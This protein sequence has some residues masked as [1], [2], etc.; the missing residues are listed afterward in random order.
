NEQTYSEESKARYRAERLERE[1]SAKQKQAQS[2]SITER[3]RLY[4]ELLSQLS[5]NDRA[6][7]DLLRRGLTPEKIEKLL[8]RSVGQWHP[9]HHAMTTE[10]P[11]VIGNGHKL[12][13]M[14][15]GYLVP[16]PNIDGLIV[17]AQYRVFEPVNGNKYPWLTSRTKNN[18]GGAKPNLPNG[19]LPIGVYR[20]KNLTR[21]EVVGIAEGYLKPSIA[22]DKVGH[23]CL[24]VAGG[25]YA[26]SPEQFTEALR[27]I[28][29]EQGIKPYLLL[30]PDAG[31]VQNDHVMQTYHR[32]YK[33]ATKLGYE[34]KVA[35]YGQFS[36]NKHQDIDELETVDQITEISWYQFLGLQHKA[37]AD[38]SLS[39]C[40]RYLPDLD[41]PEDAKLIGLKSPKGT[42]KTEY[43][44]RYVDAHRGAKRFLVICHRSQLTEQLGHRLGL[45]T[46]YELENAKG[47][48][49]Y[50]IITEI[51]LFG[52]VITWDSLHKINP[53]DWKGCEIIID[54]AE[55]S[56]WHLLN[57]S[58]EIESRRIDTLTMFSQLLE[59][60]DRTWL[61]DADLTNTAIEFT[62][63]LCNRKDFNPYIINN[64][65][66]FKKPWQITMYRD[67][68]A[69]HLVQVLLDQLGTGKRVICHLD[70]QKTKGKYSGKN[71]ERLVKNQYPHLR[72]LLIDSFTIQDP[73]HPTYRILTDE[74]ICQRLSGYD[75]VICTPTIET[76]VDIKTHG[77]FDAVFGI[78]HGVVSADSARQAL[79]RYREPV[80]RHVWAAAS[81]RM[82]GSADWKENLRM[83]DRAT[84]A[85]IRN[86]QD[87]D[88][89]VD[90]ETHSTCLDTWAKMM[91]RVKS[92]AISFRSSIEI[93]LR[94]EGHNIAIP[95]E[96]NEAAAKNLEALREI[97]NENRDESYLSERVAISNAPTV[98]DEQ[99]Q[100]IEELRSRTQSEA[101]QLRKH[102]LSK[103]YG[104]D[105]TP[106]L[107]EADDDGLRRKL[108]L[109]YYLTDGRKYLKS[110]DKE[111]L[112]KV[113]NSKG[114][115]WQPTANKTLLQ[116]KIALL[117]KLGI[118]QLLVEPDREY[119]GS[120]G[121]LIKFAK[122]CIKHRYELKTSFGM[123]IS[124]VASPITI[125]KQV[126]RL[127][128][129][130]PKQISRDK[131]ANGKAGH[132]VYKLMSII[133]HDLRHEVI[134]N[135]LKNDAQKMAKKT[136]ETVTVSNLELDPPKV[137]I[138]LVT[139]GGSNCSE[140]GGYNP[141]T[142][143]ILDQSA[144]PAPPPPQAPIQWHAGMRAMCDGF[145]YVIKQLGTLIVFLQREGSPHPIQRDISELTPIPS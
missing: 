69:N 37:L 60:C 36:K 16:I 81:A 33:L 76:G 48:Y 109:S 56:I 87:A 92:D 9:L 119:R 54:E 30:Y 59:N 124:P 47:Q 138:D 133:D 121:D 74:N 80:E 1:A 88:R 75:L 55:Q 5:L 106:E 110:R 23:I 28:T 7:N 39:I 13:V 79:S 77:L 52:M 35:W 21:K 135:W 46:H 41:I 99:A 57:A 97:I 142:G 31:A 25:N 128:G 130:S 117:D 67:N 125:L 93:G 50:G 65:Y 72:V 145:E 118:N 95:E 29:L 126:L 120:D 61:L 40:E 26:G 3:D 143:F 64:T 73:D 104:V 42:G 8:F 131:L 27:Q 68:C 66:L 2:L 15:D 89:Q 105:V 144:P 112:D 63:K 71:I 32:T 38:Q 101:Y 83:Q 96:L 22:T 86:L 114:E 20:P 10:L 34:V 82:N 49:R 62:Q 43:L 123:T 139:I 108:Q 85:N 129:F 78:F 94:D 132:R 84:K 127:I 91:A 102:K 14:A 107:I 12:N 4:R 24:G 70:S 113:L 45:R 136:A 6:K 11:G 122:R 103:S 44:A 18:E 111:K 19:E 115:L 17:G 98:T 100:H 116:G 53:D 140:S 51:N 134:Q 137:I 90:T 141:I 58:T